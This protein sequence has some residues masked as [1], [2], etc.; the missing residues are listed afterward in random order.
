MLLAVALLLPLGAAAGWWAAAMAQRWTRRPVRRTPAMVATALIWGAIGAI[1]FRAAEGGIPGPLLPTWLAVAAVGMALV[2]VDLREHRL[3]NPLVGSL[4]L[5][6]LAGLA[7]DALA[8][9]T[10][11]RLGPAAASALMWLGVIGAVW[12]I[13]GGRG[14]GMGDVKLAPVLGLL[15]GWIGWRA[16]LL[17][18]ASVWLLG[19]TVAAWLLISRRARPG[20]EMPFGPALLAGTAAGCTLGLP[21]A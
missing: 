20:E 12:A 21:P 3:P 19:G 11:V 4:M 5:I 15:L 7:A 9:G 1:S 16:S 8:T 17:G 6:S 13:S 10:L 14:L 2:L 18:L